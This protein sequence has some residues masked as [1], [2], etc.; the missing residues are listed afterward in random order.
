MSD[1]VIAGLGQYPVGEQWELSLRSLAAK[2]MLA[3]IKDAGGLKPQAV[4]VGNLLAPVISRQA[5]LGSLLADNIGLAGVEGCTAE[6][7]GASGAA[8][9]HLGYL[10]ISSGYVDAALLPEVAR[11]VPGGSGAAPVFL[12]GA[13]ASSALA[14]GAVVSSFRQW[15]GRGPLDGVAVRAAGCRQNVSPVSVHPGRCTVQ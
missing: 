13:A 2:A 5:N 9:F 10:A 12:C 8:A 15:G 4:Y 3:A 7:A 6:A 1:V 14:L 11:G